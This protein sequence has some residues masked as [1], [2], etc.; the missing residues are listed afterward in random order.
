MSARSTPAP[1]VDRNL[2]HR[3]V[4]R[5][6]RHLNNLSEYRTLDLDD[7]LQNWIRQRT[8]ERTLHQAIGICRDIADHIVADRGLRVS[9]TPSG[10]FHELADAGVLDRELA[11]GVARLVGFRTILA[12]DDVRIDPQAVLHV[13]KIEFADLERF[14]DAVVRLV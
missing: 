11:T 12:N 14:R 1:I 5:L 3:K 2:I 8:V 6:E 13:M 4:A 9:R 7:Y 10:V